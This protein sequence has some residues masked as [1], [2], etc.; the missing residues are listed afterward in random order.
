[1]DDI[2]KN[3]TDKDCVKQ[4]INQVSIMSDKISKKEKTSK[5]LWILGII[6][7]VMCL[8]L[9]VFWAD[10]AIRH[11]LADESDKLG[12]TVG[13]IVF[14]AYFGLPSLIIGSL[15]VI[16]NTISLKKGKK[17]RIWKIITLVVSILILITSIVFFILI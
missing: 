12:T 17:Q 15:S 5:I 11:L 10:I 16:F 6:T 9:T 13:L 2:I 4:D 3:D 7:A 8:I 1:M 14:I